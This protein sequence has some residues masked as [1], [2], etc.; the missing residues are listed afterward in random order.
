VLEE[1]IKHIGNNPECTWLSFICD[2]YS[3]L[4]AGS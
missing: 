2:M 1:I 4:K 3:E